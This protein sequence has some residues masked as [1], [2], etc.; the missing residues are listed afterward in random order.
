MELKY[1]DTSNVISSTYE[2][3]I[4]IGKGVVNV[5]TQQE[6]PLAGILPLA[7]CDVPIATTSRATY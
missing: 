4:K 7:K 1:L 5:S 6:L 2:M 3:K